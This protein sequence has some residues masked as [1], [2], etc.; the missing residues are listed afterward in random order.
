MGRKIAL[1]DAGRFLP[2]DLDLGGASTPQAE[3]LQ[4]EEGMPSRGS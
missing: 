3:L 2:T 4:I 1:A